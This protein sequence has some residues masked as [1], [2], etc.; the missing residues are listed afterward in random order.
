[1]S[2]QTA[3]YQ[4]VQ[5]DLTVV[6][7]NELMKATPFYPELCTIVQSKGVDE[8]Y[9]WLGDT[10]GMREWVGPRKFKQLRAADY[11]LANKTW[12]ASLEVEKEHIEDDR[13]GGY[14]AKMGQLA[15]EAAHHPD[16]LLFENVVNL[17][18]SQAC[19]DGQ[20]FF[21]TD[22][23]W[24]DSGTQSNDLTYNA[25]DH[26]NVTEAEFRAAFHQALVAMLGFK[27][28]QGKPYVRPTIGKLGN[29]LV[30]VPLALY[31]TALKS[32]DQTTLATGETNWVIEKP[33]VVVAQYMGAGFTNGSDVKFDLYYTGGKLK[34]Y[35]FQARRPLRPLQWK[36]MN[37][38][39]TRVLKAMTDARYN[40]GYLCW[41]YA[42]RTTFN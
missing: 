23:E 3:S 20:Y 31:E 9:A 2:L 4:A 40:I 14:K 13:M 35:V 7:R 18:E 8:K 22:H 11:T 6:F 37:D 25:S 17:G 29:L 38:A 26:T 39:E 42:V 34:P 16:E 10:P 24:G 33:R 36:G 41:W 5:R 19:F 32:F 30:V 21:D 1:M 15:V 12:E 28:D 27:N